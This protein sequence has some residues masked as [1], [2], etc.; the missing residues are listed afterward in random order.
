MTNLGDFSAFK[1]A[2]AGKPAPT[3]FCVVHMICERYK[4]LWEL[5]CQRWRQ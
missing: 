5:A 3:G 2:I 1:Y 4:T